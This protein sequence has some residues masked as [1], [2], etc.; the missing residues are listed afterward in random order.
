MNPDYHKRIQLWYNGVEKQLVVYLYLS[1]TNKRVR[2]GYWC[3]VS[4]DF[5]FNGIS[6]KH[7]NLYN[8]NNNKLEVYYNYTRG[9]EN[10]LRRKHEAILTLIVK[11]NVIEHINEYL[12]HYVE[13]YNAERHNMAKYMIMINEMLQSETL[14]SSTLI[15]AKVYK[16]FSK[17]SVELR[18]VTAIKDINLILEL[19]HKHM[20]KCLDKEL[21]HLH[22]KIN[23]SIARLGQTLPAEVT[24]LLE[25]CEKCRTNFWYDVYDGCNHKMC[26]GC[27][28]YSLTNLKKC[29]MC[30]YIKSN[31]TQKYTS[32]TTPTP[33]TTPK[34][35]I[36][37]FLKKSPFKPYN[38]LNFHVDKPSNKLVNKQLS[39]KPKNPKMQKNLNKILVDCEI[40]P[41]ELAREP[42]LSVSEEIKQQLQQQTIEYTTAAVASIVNM[43]QEV[44]YEYIDNNVDIEEISKLP[45]SEDFNV[46][47]FVETIYDDL[48]SNQ[49]ELQKQTELNKRKS[50]SPNKAQPTKSKNI[51]KNKSI[52]QNQNR[53]RS[54]SSSSSSSSSRSNCSRSSS[55]SSSRSNCSVI[56]SSV[57]NTNKSGDK[58]KS[59]GGKSMITMNK[60]KSPGGKSMITMDK[61]KSPMK[62]PGGKSM[63]TMNKMKSPGK[64]M[65]T[66]NNSYISESSEDDDSDEDEDNANINHIVDDANNININCND[67]NAMDID[68]D[69]DNNGG[70]NEENNGNVTDNDRD[71]NDN[72]SD[73]I[74]DKGDTAV[75]NVSNE[76]N[77]VNNNN[78]DE[79]D[80]NDD[81]ENNE[82][83][84]NDENDENN[85]NDEINE[86]NEINENNE[87]NENDDEDENVNDDNENNNETVTNVTTNNVSDDAANNNHVIDVAAATENVNADN[88]AVYEAVTDDE[89]EKST[90]L[91]ADVLDVVKFEDLNENDYE[92]VDRK[93]EMY[94]PPPP[95]KKQRTS[96]K[97]NDDDDV[98]FIGTEEDML[99]HKPETI[100]TKIVKRR[101]RKRKLTSSTAS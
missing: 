83:N 61:M 96:T 87:N 66:I 73:N 91:P 82:N 24:D 30:D 75:N 92:I 42:P 22:Q 45:E 86:I 65:I 8:N 89:N 100:Q 98:I 39:S 36:Q 67:D 27:T 49:Q 13:F 59:P 57:M 17:L 101:I 94:P 2:V 37:Q 46:N 48:P 74:S 97:D 34:K 31:Y 44:L 12:K 10:P 33:L 71:E 18:S 4:N 21:E 99:K 58:I 6:F 64:K 40:M 79:N 20:R 7:Y 15:A 62:S 80:E 68:N 95:R 11:C 9:M 38:K 55:S 50:R 23:F 52:I 5:K 25:K 3:E 41:V 81:D 77:D 53:S 28:F 70:G 72:A 76:N 88:D 51:T 69:N 26:M 1:S 78:D 47:N 35:S 84:E 85:E 90:D 63:I 54:S 93:I 16:Q 19:A 29:L 14:E 43:S 60:I 56:Q 32:Y